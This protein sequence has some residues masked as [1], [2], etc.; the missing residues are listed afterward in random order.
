MSEHVEPLIG[1]LDKRDGM[2]YW[3]KTSCSDT[4][5][6]MN[7]VD[8]LLQLLTNYS[9]DNDLPATTRQDVCWMIREMLPNRHPGLE[10][11]DKQ[12]PIKPKS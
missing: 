6:I 10:Y 5:E 9:E 1:E 8:S 7:R 12:F 11:I 4:Y 2:Y 3:V